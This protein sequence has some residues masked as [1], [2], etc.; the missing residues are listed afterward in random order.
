M[1]G[2]DTDQNCATYVRSPMLEGKRITHA[3][4]QG[5]AGAD[6]EACADGTANGNHVQ[7]A[8]PH[9]PV[10][11]HD[12]GAVVALPEARQ[13][14]AHPRHETLLANRGRGLGGV[15]S[16]M[17]GLEARAVPVLHVHRGCLCHGN[18]FP[19]SRERICGKEYEAKVGLRGSDRKRAGYVREGQEGRPS[20]LCVEAEAKPLDS[21][22]KA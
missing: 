5:A 2:P 1:P 18:C 14:K 9:G 15:A 13:V 17:L 4:E 6:E 21:K 16:L 10:Q 11:L 19:K 20:N 8:R 12:L 7:M 22:G 3:L